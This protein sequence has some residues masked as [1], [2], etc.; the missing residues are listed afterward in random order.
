VKAFFAKLMV[1]LLL[2]AG[3]VVWE[4][5]RFE[6]EIQAQGPVLANVDLLGRLVKLRQAVPK[7]QVV[8]AG[9]SKAQRN[10]DPRVFH[11]AGIPAINVAVESTDLWTFVRTIEALQWQSWNALFIISVGSY[12]INDGNNDRLALPPE[13][14]FD[15]TPAERLA[16][17]RGGYFREARSQ[18]GQKNKFYFAQQEARALEL[19][20]AFFANFGFM[21]QPAAEFTCT[22][23]RHN[24][25]VSQYS[26]HRDIRTNGGRWRLFAEAIK[27]LESWGGRYVLYT[28]PESPKG[29]ACMQGTYVEDLERQF[30]Q[31]V[32]EA[33]KGLTRV[34]FVDLYMDEALPLNDS[35][36]YDPGHM[37]SAGAEIFSRWWLGALKAL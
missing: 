36:Y 5:S 29:R 6:E 24:S 21:S 25:G 17:F 10:L 8:I 23:F 2:A 18:L 14:Y 19:E 28:S 30:A 13:M 12:Q 35:H 9:D 37:N 34:R 4:W 20:N 3:A 11:Q 26:S 33:V 27:K 22:R 7:A 16:M 31:K 1:L 32:S 15:F